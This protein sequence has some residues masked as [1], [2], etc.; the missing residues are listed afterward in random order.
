[1]LPGVLWGQLLVWGRPSDPPGSCSSTQVA[2]VGA[3]CRCFDLPPRSAGRRSP[4]VTSAS[5]RCSSPV[6]STLILIDYEDSDRSRLSECLLDLRGRGLHT[7]THTQWDGALITGPRGLH[8]P[9]PALGY[10]IRLGFEPQSSREE[11]VKVSVANQ[12]RRLHQRRK[13][14]I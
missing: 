5:P 9:G 7:H 8:I 13:G 1:M 12:L 6:S 10:E 2:T 4:A 14:E 11:M 3:G